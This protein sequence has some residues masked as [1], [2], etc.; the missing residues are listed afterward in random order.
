MIHHFTESLGQANKTLEY[1]ACERGENLCA[2]KRVARSRARCC[3]R[4]ARLSLAVGAAS[5]SVWRRTQTA[6]TGVRSRC[7]LRCH[8]CCFVTARFVATSAL[9]LFGSAF[10]R[11]LSAASRFRARTP[12]SIHTVSLGFV[13]VAVLVGAAQHG[14]GVRRVRTWPKL[15]LI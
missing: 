8:M 10:T 6:C 14:A 13:A 1:D 3:R 12:S 2:F 11:S 15:V 4:W 7:V 5:L 9:V